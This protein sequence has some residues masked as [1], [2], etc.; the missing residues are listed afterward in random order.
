MDEGWAFIDLLDGFRV[1]ELIFAWVSLYVIFSSLLY[2]KT[3]CSKL[4]MSPPI[5]RAPVSLVEPLHMAPLAEP[6][7]RFLTIN[8]I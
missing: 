2:P 6:F 4:T 7:W 1:R 3:H 5:I 8:I